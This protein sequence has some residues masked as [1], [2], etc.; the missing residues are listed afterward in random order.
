M[1][2]VLNCEFR[3][4]LSPLAAALLVFYAGYAIFFTNFTLK[5]GSIESIFLKNF[6]FYF[7]TLLL[8]TIPLT[9]F[10]YVGTEF[11]SGYAGKIISNGLSRQNYLKRKLLFSIA[12]SFLTF[13]LYCIVFC[14]FYFSLSFKV[15]S[16]FL[17]SSILTFVICILTICIA[18]CMTVL[19]KNGIISF[20]VYYGYVTIEKLLFDLKHVPLPLSYLVSFFQLNRTNTPVLFFSNVLITLLLTCSIWAFTFFRFKRLP[21]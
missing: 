17:Q 1:R 12:I 2:N 10:I 6:D 15:D 7:S 20:F 9:I 19:I 21:L 11:K 16:I 5:D 8:F 3:K 4:Y 13:A 14:C 18:T